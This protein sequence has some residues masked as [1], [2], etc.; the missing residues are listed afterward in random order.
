MLL[1]TVNSC[2]G[3]FLF[4]FFFFT[5]KSVCR[6]PLTFVVLMVDRLF[7][8]ATPIHSFFHWAT[9]VCVDNVSCLAADLTH[10]HYML[11]HEIMSFFLCHLH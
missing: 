4:L 2:Q 10:T 11:P 7:R 9:P 6:C 5:P 8:Y 1:T 3:L